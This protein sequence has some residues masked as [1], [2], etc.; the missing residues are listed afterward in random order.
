MDQ[1]LSAS[2]SVN[3]RPTDLDSV[4]HHALQGSEE[5]REEERSYTA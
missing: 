2:F 5:G 4:A 1:I 3:Q